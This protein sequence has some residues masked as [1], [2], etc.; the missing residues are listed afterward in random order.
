MRR[1]GLRGGLCMALW[2]ALGLP[3]G[4]SA[5]AAAGPWVDQDQARLRLLAAAD[6]VGGEAEALS[7]GLQVAL[8][9][10]WKIYWRSPGDAGYP[11]QIDWAG[12][13]NL[14]ETEIAWPLPHRFS[15]FGLE[16]F[17]Y[18]DEVVLPVT[19]RLERP[20]APVALRAAVDY[21]VCAEVCVPQQAALTLDLPV[22]AGD[23]TRHAFLIDSFRA[24]VPALNPA[25]DLTIERAVLR[26]APGAGAL[27]VVA[28]SEA[29]LEAPDVMVEGPPGFSYGK[30]AVALEDERR[31]AVLTLPI[32]APKNQVLEGKRLRLTLADGR[33]GIEQ[34]VIARYASGGAPAR[35]I[36]LGTLAGILGLAFLGGLIL[37]L[38]PCVLPVLSLKLLAVAKQGGRAPRAIRVSFLASAAGILS[39]FLVLAS[40]AVA[41]KMAGLAVGW[42]I[43][44]QQ[45]LFLAAM[46]VVVTLFACNLFGLFEIGLPRWAARLGAVGAAPGSE[47]EGL[48]APFLTGAFATLLATP[49][50]APFLGTA[51][52]FALARGPLEIFAIFVALALG[53]AAPYLL[54]AAVP[55]LAA[56]LPRPGPW[57]T[58]LRRILGLALAATA[59]WLLSVIAAQVGTAAAAGVAA[60]LLAL[61]VLLALTRRAPQRRLATPALVGVLALAAVL[62]PAG[63]ELQSRGDRA[64]TAPEGLWQPLDVA[65]IPALV[66]EGK[67][68][69]VDVT[70][71]WCITCQVNKRLVLEFDDVRSRLEKG[72]VIALRGDWT[73]PDDEIA[74]YLESFGRYGIPFNAVYGPGAP[75][76]IALPELLS[77]EGVT[78]AFAQAAGG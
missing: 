69:F 71:D 63:F 13:E 40:L 73:V 31:R 59:V 15:L 55:A 25:S 11:P 47:R 24:R 30:P 67:T 36:D 20:G 61:A 46:A 38:M 43:Q 60:L 14:A 49:C 1:L 34:E 51:V 77:V 23:A 6:A 65:R 32:T 37:N 56:R 27:E 50:S 26:G 10:G 41:L 44:F 72:D 16:T 68:V 64:S 52:G 62:L 12:S 76:G 7:L 42:G 28:R 3:A 66:A 8:E 18:S 17:G 53:L 22:G 57:M 19:A 4:P 29:P 74:R 33:R 58:V 9:P 35:A 2:V 39:A 45:P 75:T 5:L 70:A 48:T 78:S 21:L 54:V